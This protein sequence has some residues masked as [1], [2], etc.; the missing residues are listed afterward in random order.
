MFQHRDLSRSD[1]GHLFA[2]EGFTE[3]PTFSEFKLGTF[4][5]SHYF[6]SHYHPLIRSQPILGND[7]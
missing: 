4:P 5:V 6:I 2:F 7:N 1:L 3:Y